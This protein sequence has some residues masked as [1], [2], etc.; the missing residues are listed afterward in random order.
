MPGKS[1][2]KILVTTLPRLQ[3]QCKMKRVC[4]QKNLTYCIGVENDPEIFS[5]H[6]L[7]FPK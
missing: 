4:L 7:S 1:I 6:S 3:P 2:G 5:Y